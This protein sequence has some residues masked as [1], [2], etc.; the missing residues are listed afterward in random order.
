MLKLGMA[1]RLVTGG[2]A[3][4]LTRLPNEANPDTCACQW[5]DGIKLMTNAFPSCALA[6]AYPLPFVPL[7]SEEE[8]MP[9][10]E[11]KPF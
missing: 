7:L 5:F 10:E 2:P 6:K 1:V 3:M 9:S 8:M 11:A 4:V